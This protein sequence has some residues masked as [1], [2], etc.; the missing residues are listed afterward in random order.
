MKKLIIKS[1]IITGI[2][3]VIGFLT[4]F[5]CAKFGDFLLIRASMTGGEYQG[6]VGFGILLEHIYPMTN[7]EGASKIT[8]LSFSFVNFITYFVLIFLIV[9]LILYIIKRI[10]DK[11]GNNK[12]RKK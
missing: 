4:N 7:G 5:L 12:N 11:K 10:K 3:N 6:Y 8:H 9:L 1:L 2:I